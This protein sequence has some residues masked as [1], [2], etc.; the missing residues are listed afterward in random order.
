MMQEWDQEYEIVFMLDHSQNRNKHKP[1][2]L[3][4]NTMN[5]GFGGEQP[6][7]HDTKLEQEK[8]LGNNPNTIASFYAA[9]SA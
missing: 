6:K 8:C 4:A 1:D 3:N 2:G 9:M 5:R 7:M